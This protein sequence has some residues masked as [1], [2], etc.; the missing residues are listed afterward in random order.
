MAKNAGRYRAAQ[1]LLSSGQ[2]MPQILPQLPVE[3]VAASLSYLSRTDLRSAASACRRFKYLV[4]HQ[5][6]LSI[7]RTISASSCERTTGPPSSPLSFGFIDAQS[8]LDP[9]TGVS[10]IISCLHDLSL[11]LD[12]NG[13]SG[14]LSDEQFPDALSSWLGDVF[15]CINYALPFLVGLNVTI[16]EA[17][18]T[19]LDVFLHHPAPHL[20]EFELMLPFDERMN[21]YSYRVPSTIFAGFAPRLRNVAL[22]AVVPCE[23]T[24]PAFTLVCAAARPAADARKT[25]ERRKKATVVSLSY[26]DPL[27]ALHLARQFPLVSTLRL[28]YDGIFDFQPLQQ[29][30]WDGLSLQSLVISDDEGRDLVAQLSS[31]YPELWHSIPSIEHHSKE[32]DWHRSLWD[33]F[34]DKLHLRV[35]DLLEDCPLPDF[36]RINFR[37]LTISPE[38]GSFARV[39]QFREWLPSAFSPN[40]PRIRGV[41][42]LAA[43][44]VYIRMDNAFLDDLRI[45]GRAGMPALRRFQ[46]DL[47]EESGTKKKKKQGIYDAKLKLTSRASCPALES[48]VVFAA[49]RPTRIT[50]THLARLVTLTGGR[51]GISM[52]PEIVSLDFGLNAKEPV[53]ERRI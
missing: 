34:P 2:K 41:A 4:Y 39:F 38:N 46:L 1:A 22:N 47:R 24:V 31:A 37:R 6:G 5:C 36:E 25:R 43:R 51:H 32:P 8:A 10:R 49:D 15:I 16:S 14:H 26:S 42:F 27:P 40:P 29:L 21:T 35:T 7:K 13:E 53:R 33:S 52:F 23:A 45:F 12:V 44:F 17:R 28:E 9:T 3:L 11:T 48:L 30:R 19:L 50:A 18:C 20:R